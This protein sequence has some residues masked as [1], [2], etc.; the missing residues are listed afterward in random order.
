MPSAPAFWL[1]RAAVAKSM[2]PVVRC[3]GSK[4]G[5]PA[6]QNGQATYI[7]GP[8]FL[9]VQNKDNPS[10]SHTG[11]LQRLNINIII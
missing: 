11:F 9:H 1:V 8:H 10:A 2:G 5:C 7:S 6:Y 4:S 3:L